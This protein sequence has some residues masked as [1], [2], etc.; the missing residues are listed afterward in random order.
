M[1][2]PVD[3]CLAVPLALQNFQRQ[4]ASRRF[5]HETCRITSRD[6]RRCTNFCETPPRMRLPMLGLLNEPQMSD[7]SYLEKI[8]NARVN[9][10]AKETP[11]DYTSRLPLRMALPQS[12]LRLRSHPR[13]YRRAGKRSRGARSS[14]RRPR[15]RP[16][17]GKRQSCLRDVPG[18]TAITRETTDRFDRAYAE[19]PAKPGLL[20]GRELPAPPA[21][22][23]PRRW[24][25]LPE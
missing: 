4:V 5:Q 1:A 15:L 12:Q 23:C 22:E 6:F 10:V 14:P 2:P 3:H 20:R 19:A 17:G 9:D 21:P 8:D 18:L 25:V 16:L 7:A 13:P 11:L 24:A